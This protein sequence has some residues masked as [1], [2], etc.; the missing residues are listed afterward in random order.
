MVILFVVFIIAANIWELR[1]DLSPQEDYIATLKEIDK[2]SF[3]DSIKHKYTC[4]LFYNPEKTSDVKMES[5][6]SMLNNPPNSPI[7]YYK[8]RSD[9]ASELCCGLNIS[10]TPSVLLFKDGVEVS[11]IMG[12]VS[13]TNLKMIIKRLEKQV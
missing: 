11:R 2:K 10:G 5:E 8:I 13:Q 1:K 4:V 9:E 3:P 6:L 12:T 7:K